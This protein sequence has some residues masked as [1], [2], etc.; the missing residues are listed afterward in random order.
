VFR[1]LIGAG[2]MFDGPERPQHAARAIFADIIN[3]NREPA[4]MAPIAPRKFHGSV[5]PIQQFAFRKIGH[6]VNDPSI[7]DA[8]RRLAPLSQAWTHR[9]AR[10]T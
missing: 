2:D 7:I 10:R 8:S 4:G 9:A 6:R 5:A 1:E 3:R